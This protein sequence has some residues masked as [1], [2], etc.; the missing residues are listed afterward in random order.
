L[1]KKIKAPGKLLR[2]GG[3]KTRKRTPRRLL[4]QKRVFSNQNT[5]VVPIARKRKK[6]GFQ[7]RRGPWVFA[8]KENC[9]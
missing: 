5:Q 2:T 9:S 7:G 1:S 8:G 6:K 3:Q 4:A